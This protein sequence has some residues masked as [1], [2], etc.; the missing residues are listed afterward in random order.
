MMHR[1]PV[2]IALIVFAAFALV[3]AGCGSGES[4][5]SASWYGGDGGETA[6]TQI[7]AVNSMD[8]PG[9]PIRVGDWIQIQGSGFG[10]SRQGK[11]SDG[12]VAFSDG[13]TVTKAVSYGQ[14]TDVI[15]ECQ[16]P[17]G[18]PIKSITFKENVS[19][20]VV[21]PDSNNNSSLYSSSVN[22][23]P[24]PSPQPT[25]P[26]PSPSPSL[27]GTPIPSPFP[28]PTPSASPTPT[29]TPTSGG[30][31]GGASP[32]TLVSVKVSPETAVLAH[33]CSPENLGEEGGA[34]SRQFTAKANYSDGSEVDVTTKCTWTTTST[35]GTVDGA[36]GK[37]TAAVD[38]DK[39]KYKYVEQSDMKAAYGGKEGTAK[40]TVGLVEV[41]GAMI[42][43]AGTAINNVTVSTFYAGQYEV[44]NREFCEFLNDMKAQGKDN[45]QEG[46]N[47]DDPPKLVTWWDAVDDN[48]NGII[49]TVDKTPRYVVRKKTV[50]NEDMDYSAR[51]VVY[52]SWYGAVAYCNWLSEKHGLVPCYGGYK[53]DGL[54]RWGADGINY[55][56]ANT[57]YRLFTEV[58]WEYA[59]RNNGNAG[60]VSTDNYYWGAILGNEY[61]DPANWGYLWFFWDCGTPGPG[62]ENHHNVGTAFPNGLGLYDMSGNVLEWANDWSGDS[63]PYDGWEPV[64]P[65]AAYTDPKGPRTGDF[66]ALRGGSWR[67][68]ADGCLSGFRFAVPPG[69]RMDFFGFR[70]AKRK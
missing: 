20:Y 58:E 69:F 49:D 41:P 32:P 7:T 24:N 68:F 23:T 36:T 13:T 63:F 18:T 64:P 50:E 12:Y 51:P 56:P 9:Q 59:C 48:F 10:S 67:N 16:V 6:V 1:S 70:I 17:Q 40:L 62:F 26:S 3:V 54:D 31:G 55:N 11:Q 43:A 60:G 5:G 2:F 14:W 22:P 30:G 52:V 66:R 35:V 28:T 4:D 21:K 39:T 45:P 57:G 37:Y 15:V 65:A 46:Y 38:D 42:E 34:A 33:K 61:G 47:Y 53:N 29:P 8:L 19:I 27:T 44:T 25:P